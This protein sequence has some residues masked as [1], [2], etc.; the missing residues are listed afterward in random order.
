MHPEIDVI[1]ARWKWAQGVDGDFVIDAARVDGCSVPRAYRN[2][3]RPR[4]AVLGTLP[5]LLS[6]R[7]VGGVNG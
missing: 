3:E 6:R 5:V 7:I 4:A 2:V 1:A